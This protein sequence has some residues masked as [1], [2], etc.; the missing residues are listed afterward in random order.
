V[1]SSWC[2]LSTLNNNFIKDEVELKFR[3]ILVTSRQHRRC[4]IP[5]AV[6]RVWCS[7]AWAILSP[8][9]CWADWKY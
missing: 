8:E 6:N 9:T 7:W 3:L 2:F 4:F 1:T 5:Q